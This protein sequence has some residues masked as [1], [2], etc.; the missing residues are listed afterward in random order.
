MTPSGHKGIVPLVTLDQLAAPRAPVSPAHLS[1]HNGAV[2]NAVEVVVIFWG[3]E[4]QQAPQNALVPQL[5]QFFDTILASPYA[6]FLAE[7]SVPVRAIGHGRRVS[8]VTIT[9]SEP[10]DPVPGGGRQV[11][12]DQIRQALQGWINAGTVPAVTSN[13]LYFVYLP[14]GVTS[15]LNGD[16]SCQV[17]CGYHFSVGN[18]YYAVEPYLTCAGCTYGQGDL[19][20]L[21]KVSSH[22]LTEAITNPQ[23]TFDSNDGGWW[24][25]NLL[26]Q[27]QPP[28]I[29]DIC[30]AQV[31]QYAGYTIQAE[32]SNQQNSCVLPQELRP[33]AVSWGASRL[34]LFG[35]GMDR[36]LYHQWW[37]GNSWGPAPTGWEPRGG[38]FIASPVAV[39]SAPNRL[40]LFAL[41]TNRQLYRQWWDGHS[42]GPSATGWESHGGAFIAPPIAVSS[43]ANRLDLFGLGSDRQI[44]HQW[45]DG[46]SWRPG[47]T[48]W[49]PRGG[50][51]ITPPVAVS[52]GANRLDL[53]GLGTDR[54][55]YHQWWDGQNW[56][57]SATGWEPRGGTFGAL[58]GAVSWGPNRLDLFGLGT[59]RQLHHQWWDGG[60]WHPSSTGWEPR[61]GTFI[62][63]P[64]AVSWG[65]N[66]LDLFGLGMDRQLYHQWLDGSNWRPSVTG[67]EPRG[68]TF[69]APPLAVSW[70]PNRLDLLGLGTDRR[71]Y[72][73]WLDGGNWGPSR[74]GWEPR[75]G[76]LT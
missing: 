32:W 59:D 20:S 8:T 18:I 24:D 19:D 45:W 6:E 56:G 71:L 13:T 65:A 42:W 16:A 64:A 10:G 49:E 51:F 46:Q 67:W 76:R 9:S 44:F 69:I 14:P 61:G 53:F 73:Q 58:P 27:G 75:G 70:G 38:M 37:G 15:L 25:D 41:G 48:D 36:Q 43:G 63:P 1:Y 55:L 7:Y 26:Q 30:N 60:G 17:F 40:D 54:Q 35:L 34:D 52:R 28:E 3:P 22:E 74:T 21:T 72:H 39:S 68:G 62:A 12:D 57:P 33:A 4:W 5:N 31:A 29:G 47:P 50:T 11:T 66:R 23:A 2:L